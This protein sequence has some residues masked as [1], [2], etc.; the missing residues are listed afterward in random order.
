MKYAA[1]ALLIALVIMGIETKVY[2]EKTTKAYNTAIA[3][4]PDD[5]DKGYQAIQSTLVYSNFTTLGL[6]HELQAKFFEMVRERALA[7]LN[8][9][10]GLETNWPIVIANALRVLH[11][12]RENQKLASDIRAQIG[13]DQHT[14]LAAAK[15]AS[16]SLPDKVSLAAWDRAMTSFDTIQKNGWV[17]DSELND[18]EQWL[19]G[20]RQVDRRGIALRET[21][22]V[23][24]GHFGAGVK[25]L[26]LSAS[27][28]P[29]DPVI[30][31]LQKPL[32][33][34]ALLDAERNFQKAEDLC[35]QFG[36]KFNN[37]EIPPE[38]KPIWL[39]CLFN[40]ASMRVAHLV[41]RGPSLGSQISMYLLEMY[42]TPAADAIPSDSEVYGAFINTTM[43][44]LEQVSH[45]L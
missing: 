21:V 6:S 30:G 31:I 39:K 20:L 33:D 14:L 45:T 24:S 34:G 11:T 44:E 2:R 16:E 1:I 26:G 5:P 37:G 38:L 41:D 3:F 15:T 28:A 13:Q 32:R 7:N 18:Y 40:H 29:A 42:V 19:A 4:L 22:Q 35:H 23:V 36:R 10:K 12:A 43:E 8:V 17:P 25:A 9:Q 27:E